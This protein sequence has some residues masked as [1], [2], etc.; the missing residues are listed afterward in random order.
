MDPKSGCKTAAAGQAIA[1]PQASAMNVRCQGA[2][3][4]EERRKGGRA[5][6]IENQ[7]PPLGHASPFYRSPHFFHAWDTAPSLRCRMPS[8]SRVVSIASTVLC[9]AVSATLFAQRA[10]N[11]GSKPNTQADVTTR[12]AA[13]AQDFLKTLD[14]AGRSKV[15]FPFDSPQKSKW[16]NL[17][18]PM[19]QRNGARLADLTQPQRA[20]V[21]SLLSVALSQDGYRKVLDI[22]RGDEVLKK[23][24]RGGGPVFGEDE[25]FVSFV[26]TPS[27]SAPWMLQF[28]GHHL[29]INLTMAASQATMAPSLPAAQPASYTFE[30]RTVR[31][32]G[33][34][35]D[36]AFALVNALDASQR[37]QAVLNYRV[38]DLVLGPGKDG[39]TI[40]AEGIR[41][42]SLSDAQQT[43]LWDLVRE[44]VG[45]MNDAFAEPRMT[46]IRGNLRETYFA[47]S[48]PLTNGSAAYFR[49]QGPTLVIEYAPQNSVD[50]IHTIYRDPTNDYGAKIAK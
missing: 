30:G 27:D 34:E 17:P 24:G 48:G 16:S 44:W 19:Y 26:G 15:L 45:I 49:I 33:Q 2:R 23:N 8:L 29:A 38:A 10:A 12:I 32:L 20:A 5:V 35:N 4:L 25:Y 3:D 41:A 39:Q 36:K 9:I 31:P 6:Q 18:S 22:M 37:S 7:L 28:G 14:D 21:M 1:G 40:Q 43:M 42:S 11:P 13:S 50:H 46:E 47:W